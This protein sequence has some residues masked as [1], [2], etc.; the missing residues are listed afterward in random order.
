MSQPSAFPLPVTSVPSRQLELIP[1]LRSNEVMLVGALLLLGLR[2]ELNFHPAYATKQCESLLYF[3]LGG[4][5]G[6]QKEA[7]HTHSACAHTTPQQEDYLLK[8]I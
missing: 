5:G 4:I 8:K 7:E 1:L 6:A 3:C 2:V